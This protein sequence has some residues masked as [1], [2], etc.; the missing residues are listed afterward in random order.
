M[1]RDGIANIVFRIRELGFEPRRLRTDS[2]ESRCPAHQS[3]EWALSITR[4]EQV[5][6]RRRS[7]REDRHRTPSQFSIPTA[8]RSIRGKIRH[9]RRAHQRHAC[10]WVAHFSTCG[11][12]LAA[13]IRAVPTTGDPAV[14]SPSC[15]FGR[16][17]V[18]F[19]IVGL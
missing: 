18:G 6:P 16:S 19:R 14:P 9:Q 13:G 1:V 4:N 2:C 8:S 11:P 12:R 15:Q 3:A 17:R 10:P 5:L 7:F